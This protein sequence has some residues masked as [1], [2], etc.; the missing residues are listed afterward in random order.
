[1]NELCTCHRA[2]PESQ[3][4]GQLGRGQLGRQNQLEKW[5]LSRE[6]GDQD[7]GGKGLRLQRKKARASLGGCR[8]LKS[9]KKKKK[10]SRQALLARCS[11]PF[12][13]TVLPFEEGR[14]F[15]IV[16]V[17]MLRLIGVKG[18]AP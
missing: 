1:M 10:D 12:T 15:P 3:A 16:Q 7:P 5:V 6:K 18:E 4:H 17:R 14:D 2:F 8:L 9:K 11:T 13:P